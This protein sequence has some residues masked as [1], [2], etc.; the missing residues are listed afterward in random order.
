MD[1]Y[2]NNTKSLKYIQKTAKI[3]WN[4]SQFKEAS[5]L[6]DRENVLIS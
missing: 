3:S 4:K 5:H 2:I 6:N 1:S